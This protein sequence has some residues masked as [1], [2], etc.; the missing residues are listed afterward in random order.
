VF[1]HLSFFG[2]HSCILRR[3]LWCV[4]KCD[5]FIS[6]SVSSYLFHNFKQYI[7]LHSCSFLLAFFLCVALMCFFFWILSCHIQTVSPSLQ[8]L[9]L[10][11]ACAI[12]VL[13]CVYYIMLFV[14]NVCTNII[15]FF[16]VVYDAIP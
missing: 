9:L 4:Y 7:F 3:V 6:H 8:M 15:V 12:L 11:L 2:A 1:I 16:F 5:R 14:W 10:L 13:V